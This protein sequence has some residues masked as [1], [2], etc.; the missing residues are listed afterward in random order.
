MDKKSIV[1]YLHVHQPWRV[2][3]DYTVFDIGSDRGYFGE[4]TGIKAQTNGDIFKKVAEKS[5]VPMNNL[6]E[7]LLKQHPEF[8]FSISIT[9]TFIDQAI[10]FAPEVLDSFKRLVDTGRVEIVAETYYHSLAFFYDGDEFESQ[11]RAHQV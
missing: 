4:E 1:L 2:R 5:Y 3:D 9:G 6:L 10:E 8:R 7:K 11:V